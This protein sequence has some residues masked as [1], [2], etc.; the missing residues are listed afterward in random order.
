[1]IFRLDTKSV[2]SGTFLPGGFCGSGNRVAGE[3]IEKTG[4]V[5]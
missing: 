5:G 3:S 1:M 2:I 4:F